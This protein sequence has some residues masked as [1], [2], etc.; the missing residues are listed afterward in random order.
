MIRFKGLFIVLAT[1]MLSVPMMGWIGRLLCRIGFHDYQLIEVVGGFGGS[2]QVE[3]A[4]CRRG[5]CATTRS[6]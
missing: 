6:G 2:G 5:G 4:E 3:K 1:T